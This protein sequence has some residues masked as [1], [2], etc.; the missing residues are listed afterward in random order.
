VERGQTIATYMRQLNSPSLVSLFQIASRI[1]PSPSS[2]L[3]CNE[4]ASPVAEIPIQI[5]LSDGGSIGVAF[6]RHSTVVAWSSNSA[7]TFSKSQVRLFLSCHAGV[8]QCTP[9][10]YASAHNIQDEDTL[11]TIVIFESPIGSKCSDGSRMSK[12]YRLNNVSI[13]WWSSFTIRNALWPA[14]VVPVRDDVK[15]MNSH[16]NDTDTVTNL[17]YHIRTV[18]SAYVLFNDEDDGFRITW[19]TMDGKDASSCSTSNNSTFPYVP[20]KIRPSRNDIVTQ[21]EGDIWEECWSDRSSGCVFAPDD[22]TVPRHG[23]LHVAFE[24]YLHIDA[25]L[26]EIISRRQLSFFRHSPYHNERVLFMPEFFYNL[27]S[28][29]ID[30]LKVVVV[31]VFSNKEKMIMQSQK[32]VPSALGVYVEVILADQSYDEL[33][34]VQHPSCNDASSMKQWCNSLALNWR[35]MQSRV[36]VFCLD[37][38]EIDQQ[39]ESW[40]CCTHECNVNED[41]SDDRNVPLW[42]EYVDRRNVFKMQGL[43]AAPPKD[44]S[45]SSLYPHC[46][47][48]TNRAVHNAI[49]VKRITSR[50]SAVE[51][52]Y[53]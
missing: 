2:I 22:E 51:L 42:R 46:D 32:R 43:S 41:L 11:G 1:S 25:L 7:P 19:I 14:T 36:G 47:V 5:L 20:N 23:S 26:S 40:V 38:S 6:L 50:D 16:S 12:S 37:N 35:M 39:M 21:S 4:Y 10:Q 8:Y 17:F 30:S 13:G 44:V 31:I 9:S 27:V 3:D 45:M 49:P 24:L 28:A 52:I 33:K 15:L 48:I 29:S 34:W 18:L 53:G